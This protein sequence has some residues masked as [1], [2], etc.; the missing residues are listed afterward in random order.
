MRIG[1]I[2]TH[3][4]ETP[5]SQP[6]SWS[7]TGTALRT[8]CV[9]EVICEDGRVGWASASV[10]RAAMRPLAGT[11]LPPDGLS[12]GA[13]QGPAANARAGQRSQLAAVSPACRRP[14]RCR[15]PARASSGRWHGARTAARL[16]SAGSLAAIALPRRAG[17]RRLRQSHAIRA[18]QFAGRQQGSLFQADLHSRVAQDAKT[19]HV[20]GGND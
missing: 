4:L 20:K 11:A 18:R 5:L 15:G 13:T 7:F 16:G 14:A 6:F 10:R 19:G 3:V 2:K 1:E 12:P 8:S 17:R 9:V